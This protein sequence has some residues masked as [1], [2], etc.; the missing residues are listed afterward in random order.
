M[1]LDKYCGLWSRTEKSIILKQKKIQV[2][3]GGNTTGFILIRWDQK[4]PIWEE[5][6]FHEKFVYY[7]L[8]KPKGCSAMEDDRHQAVLDLLDDTARA[9]GSLSS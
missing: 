5:N 4:W 7:L 8:N 1:R 3:K 2:W 6:L 9:Q